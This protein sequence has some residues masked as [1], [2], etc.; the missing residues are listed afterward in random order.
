MSPLERLGDAKW[1]RAAAAKYGLP[2][3]DMQDIAQDTVVKYLRRRNEC[4]IDHEWAYL[5]K[6]IHHTIVGQARSAARRPLTREIMAEDA[7]TKRGQRHPTHDDIAERLDLEI[8]R[9]VDLPALLE[10]LPAKQCNVVRRWL[11]RQSIPDIA[12]ALGV[13]EG[14]I[15]R[16]LNRAVEALRPTTQT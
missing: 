1:V 7:P 15:R 5:T 8:A 13:R 16:H 6:I 12:A 14:T 4:E 3:C 9:R 10:R 11:A 2:V